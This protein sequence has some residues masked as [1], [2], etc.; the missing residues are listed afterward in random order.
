M[1]AAD[2]LAAGLDPPARRELAGLSRRDGSAELFSSLLGEF[3]LASSDEGPA[4]RRVLHHLAE[5]LTAGTATL[6]G[7]ADVV[8]RRLHPRRTEAERGFADAA[9]H[10][11]RVEHIAA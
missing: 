7:A 4:E 6:R 8:W 5:R 11:Y 3:G 10:G 1:A 9:G 2:L